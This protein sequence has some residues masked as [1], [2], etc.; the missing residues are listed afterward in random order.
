M[1]SLDEESSDKVK[2]EL[3]RLFKEGHYRDLS[4]K[5]LKLVRLFETEKKP[6]EKEGIRVANEITNELL[7]EFDSEPFDIPEENIHILPD[8]KYSKIKLH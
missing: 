8:K 2:R 6:V 3:A 7:R 1:G 5:L 4:P